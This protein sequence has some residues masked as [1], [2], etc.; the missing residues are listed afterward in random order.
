M[1]FSMTYFTL[2]ESFYGFFMSKK[3]C[4]VCQTVYTAVQSA[5]HFFPCSYCTCLIKTENLMKNNLKLEQELVEIRSKNLFL[6]QEIQALKIKNTDLDHTCEVLMREN[7]KL[8]SDLDNCIK[9][10]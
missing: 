10:E 7:T 4:Y 8:K 9:K 5:Q 1:E 2:S 3:L 6:S